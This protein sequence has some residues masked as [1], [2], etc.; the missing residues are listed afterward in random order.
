RRGRAGGDVAALARRPCG[1]ST[2][3]YVPLATRA[4]SREFPPLHAGDLGV[5]RRGLLPLRHLLLPLGRHQDAGGTPMAL[6]ES[7]QP[8]AT[9]TSGPR[10]GAG[11]AP[12]WIFSGYLA[13]LVLVYVGERVL[14]GLEKG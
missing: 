6:T 3:Q 5:P 11:S 13:G 10:A 12:G 8:V 7:K 2:A 14:S 9:A 1:R 4:P